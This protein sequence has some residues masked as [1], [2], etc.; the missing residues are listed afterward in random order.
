MTL[1]DLSIKRPVFAWMLMLGL[2]VFGAIGF[3]RLGVSQLP[4]VDFPIISVSA[5]LQGAAPEVMETEVADILEDSVMS[6][7]GVKEVSSTSRQGQT[8]ITIEFELNKDIDVAIQEVQTKVAQA[9]RNLPTDLDP[10]VISKT[11][12]EDQ[13]IMWVALSGDR[14]LRELVD[15]A[16]DH[17]KDQFTSAPGVGDVTLGGY[18]DP[19]V[20]VWVDRSKL[21]RHELTVDDVIR[22]IQSQH[23]EGADR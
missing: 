17:V 16:R 2:L 8:S 1:S 13:P 11:N 3:S 19:N 23:Q 21:F 9:Q 15:Y 6:I 22:T 14:P 5:S 10:P 18:I 4:D 20:R 12:P 7:P